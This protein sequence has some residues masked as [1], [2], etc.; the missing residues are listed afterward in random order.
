MP[1]TPFFWQRRCWA[2]FAG[3]GFSG[4]VEQVFQNGFAAESANSSVYFTQTLD[5][6]HPLSIYIAAE[7]WPEVRGDSRVS[8]ADENLQIGSRRY[9]RSWISDEAVAA[10]L[11]DD[12]L[13]QQNLLKLKSNI[14]LF[15][16]SSPVKDLLFGCKTR[17][18]LLDGCE[19]L[20][21]RFPPDLGKLENLLGVGEGLTPSF[22]DLLCGM[23]LA[24]RRLGYHQITVP[25]GFFAAAAEKTT[26]Q[27]V[28]QLEFAASGYL[29]IGLERIVAAMSC[30]EL[31]SAEIVAALNYGHS[32]GTDI[33]CGICMYFLGK[34]VV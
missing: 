23:L 30:R 15:G 29:N 14:R 34:N 7:D 9:R 1:D 6:C 22:D 19:Q 12:A 8:L 24:D 5:R 31:R 25:H 28:Q 10:C 33:L 13:L 26:R 4:R 11:R 32:S 21:T 17:V 2:D 27:S 20:L 3:A 16:R 18:N